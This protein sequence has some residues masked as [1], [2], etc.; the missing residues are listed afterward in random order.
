[1]TAEIADGGRPTCSNELELAAADAEGGAEDPAAVV[2]VVAAE[3]EEE[4]VLCPL[5]RAIAVV[6]LVLVLV[7]VAAVVGDEAPGRLQD[8]QGLGHLHRRNGDGR[9]HGLGRQ[10]GDERV[11]A[12]WFGLVWFGLV[13]FG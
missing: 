8:G 10:G 13:W 2:V 1:M 6:G 7:L 4:D 12:V 5:R 11:L 9:D 3:E